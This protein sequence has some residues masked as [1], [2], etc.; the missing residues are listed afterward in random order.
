MKSGRGGA[1][2]GAGRK[3]EKLPADVIERLGPPP[4][5]P[6]EL[7]TWNAKLLAEVQYLSIRGLIATDLAASIRANAGALDRALPIAKGGSSGDGV[8]GFDGDDDDE[9]EDNGPQLDA[10]EG[11]RVG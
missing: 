10:F 4:S 8:D 7:R 3:R 2:A 9:T 1:R 11:V 5:T 6:D